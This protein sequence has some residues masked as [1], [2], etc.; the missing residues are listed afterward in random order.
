M[1]LT[2]Q[3]C[4]SGACRVRIDGAEGRQQALLDAIRLCRVSAGACQ[5]GACLHVESI[6]EQLDERGVS[7]TIAPRAGAKLSAAAVASCLRYMLPD[8]E[9]T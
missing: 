8:L 9:K 1:K 6:S 2:V 5:S 7:L 4:E 3:G